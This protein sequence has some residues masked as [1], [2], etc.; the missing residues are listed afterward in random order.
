MLHLERDKLGSIIYSNSS[1]LFLQDNF[2][3]NALTVSFFSLWMYLG[4]HAANPPM[5]E[6]EAQCV[7][8]PFINLV[9][10]N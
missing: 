5:A 9:L 3:G 2:L 8:V 10:F 4:D 7:T 6:N 1:F